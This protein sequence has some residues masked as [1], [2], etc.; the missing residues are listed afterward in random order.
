M[1]TQIPSGKTRDVKYYAWTVYEDV[2]VTKNDFVTCNEYLTTTNL[3]QVLL[4]NN[5]SGAAVAT[6]TTNNIVEV[7]AEVT[8]VECTLFVFGR[9]T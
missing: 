6:S 4:V 3:L 1:V 7:T 2:S 8:N 9:R 5:A